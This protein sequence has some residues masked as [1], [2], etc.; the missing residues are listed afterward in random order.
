VI[1]TLL[2]DIEGT[3]VEHGKAVPGA[4]D[5]IT[6]LSGRG[7]AIRF[8][9]NI[10]SRP[11]EDIA[12]ELLDL[13]FEGITPGHIQTAAC[14]ARQILVREDA[15]FSDLLIP[16]RVVHLF[17][18]LHLD[19]FTPDYVVVGDVG[20]GFDYETMNVAFRLLQNG[21][22][23]LALQRNLHWES[24]DGAVL[25][26]GAFVSALEAATGR[27]AVLAGK[28]SASFFRGALEELGAE[29]RTAL[30]VGDDQLTDIE[31]AHAIGAR[32]A[33]VKT[34]KGTRSNSASPL[35]HHVLAS[36]AE[37]PALLDL[38]RSQ[39]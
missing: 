28:P 30:I 13:G 37:L 6:E 15:S 11:P 39:H 24:T 9:T 35:P 3:L 10:S 17:D 26:A 22:R 19:R 1:E 38:L 27:S 25:D 4:A 14:A 34:G 21:A 7:F 23:L 36:V 8:L 29:E 32:A 31:G 12:R 33:I 18:G 5:A 20:T 16:H 2:I